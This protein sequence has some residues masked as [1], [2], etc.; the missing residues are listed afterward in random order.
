MIPSA[1][2]SSPP[3]PLFFRASLELRPYLISTTTK[4]PSPSLGAACWHAAIPSPTLPA[5]RSTSCPSCCDRQNF[6]Q[7][8]VGIVRLSSMNSIGSAHADRPPAPAADR[9]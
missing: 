2:P 1:D 8:P 5:P 3:L 9:T 6:I 4:P 7:Y